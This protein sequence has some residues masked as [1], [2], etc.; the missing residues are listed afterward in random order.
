MADSSK[1]IRS[2]LSQAYSDGETTVRVEIYRPV[3][4]NGWT[5]DVTD[6][7]GYSR[8]DDGSSLS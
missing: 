4:A 1:I 8:G 5:L 7:H 6:E 3:E 2:A